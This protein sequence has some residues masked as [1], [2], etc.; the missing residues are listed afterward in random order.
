MPNEV[1]TVFG[2]KIETNIVCCG[3]MR[4]GKDADEHLMECHNMKIASGLYMDDNYHGH[5][6]PKI[7]I[8]VYISEVPDW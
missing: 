2:E 5:R 1:I 6:N 8:Y 7:I 3:E 4:T